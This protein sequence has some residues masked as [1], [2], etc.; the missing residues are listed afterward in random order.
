MFIKKIS[1]LMVSVAVF[2]LNADALSSRIDQPEKQDCIKPSKSITVYEAAK[3][4]GYLDN[5]DLVVIHG[6][7]L[8]EDMGINMS[9]TFS[10][11][12]R[13]NIDKETICRMSG[14]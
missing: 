12:L 6:D 8:Q 5:P 9:R 2:S 4:S 3:V 10:D 7:N 13:I 14:E 1:V 11:N